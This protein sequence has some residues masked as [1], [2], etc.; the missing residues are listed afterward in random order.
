M[1]PFPTRILLATDGS[2][3]A[4]LAALKAVDLADAARSRFSVIASGCSCVLARDHS[5]LASLGRRSRRAA[6]RAPKTTQPAPAR[7]AAW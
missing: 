1:G 6:M 4:E 3:E 2:E 7:K 5:C